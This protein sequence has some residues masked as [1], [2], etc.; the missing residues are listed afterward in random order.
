MPQRENASEF[1]ANELFRYVKI[2]PPKIIDLQRR[3]RAIPHLR[4]VL[5]KGEDAQRAWAA[6]HL[7]SK[8]CVANEEDLKLTYRTAG[9]AD[10][11]GPPEQMLAPATQAV[12]KR[13]DQPVRT[14]KSAKLDAQRTLKTALAHKILGNDAAALKACELLERI[15]GRPQGTQPPAF[16]VLRRFPHKTISEPPAPMLPEA[17]PDKSVEALQKLG[18]DIQLLWR[19]RNN[20]IKAQRTKLLI[21]EKVAGRSKPGSRKTGRRSKKKSSKQAKKA[22]R[23]YVKDLRARRRRVEKAVATYREIESANTMPKILSDDSREMKV[24][25]R[26]LGSERKLTKL[27]GDIKKAMRELDV[28]GVTACEV[29]DDAMRKLDKTGA[30]MRPPPLATLGKCF[31]ENPRIKFGT[32]IRP[33]GTAALIKVEETFVK[34]TEGEIN[35]IENILAGETRRR[36]IKDT[37]YSEQLTET[38]T[39]EI[40]DIT[41]EVSSKVSSNLRST[42]ETELNTSFNTDVNATASGSGGGSIGVVDFDGTAALN[43]GFGIGVDTGLSTS[44]ESNFAP[45]DPQ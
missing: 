9:E 6:K 31:S 28:K 39:E 4:N 29:Y 37:K 22:A 21:E 1:A 20:R 5:S 17:K 36:E 14:S 15:E 23:A 24:A 38:S 32:Q 30:A 43:A 27:Q 45:G 44:T 2:T 35:Y 26:A 19:A 18:E 7:E 25:V 10:P 41:E 34:Y 40:T 12:A 33:M 42:I 16:P 11:S 13:Y 3:A 8:Q